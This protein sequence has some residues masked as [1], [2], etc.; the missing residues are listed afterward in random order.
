M[1]E[2]QELGSGYWFPTP[3]RIVPIDGQAIVVGPS[4]THELQRHFHG[5]TRAGYARVIPQPEARALPIHEL[6]DWLGLD[7]VDSVAW[8]EAQLANAQAGM[9]PTISSA[10]VQYFSIR[11]TRLPFG[12]IASPAWTDDPR[13][14]VIGRQ[15][16]VLCRERLAP[17]RFRYFLGRLEGSR[18]VAEAPAPKD[19]ARLLF[20]LAALAGRPFTVAVGLSEV[21][22][23]IHIPANLPRPERQLTLALGVRDL[24]LPEKVYRMRSDTFVS[25]IVARLQRLGC[26]VRSIRV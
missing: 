2:A 11:T 8:S 12:N 22:S 17:E 6:D 7:I 24:S 19:V 18:L 13:S 23:V 1:R 25:L 20:G 9:G 26:E 14:T 5:L 4:P 10:S 21:E 15:T 16:V 3:L